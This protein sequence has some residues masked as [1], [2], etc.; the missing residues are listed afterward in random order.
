MNRYHDGMKIGQVDGAMI[1]LVHGWRFRLFGGYNLSLFLQSIEDRLELTIKHS[2]YSAKY[3]ALDTLLVLELTGTAIDCSS[4][5][6]YSI[7]NIDDV[8]SEDESSDT[9]YL[10]NIHIYKMFKAYWKEKFEEAGEHFQNSLGTPG[11]KTPR[12]IT[13]HQTLYGGLV[14]FQLHRQMGGNNDLR[15]QQGRAAMKKLEEWPNTHHG[16]KMLLLQAEHSGTIGE[17]DK[18]QLL[19]R[20][21][22]KAAKDHGNVHEL[23]LSYELFGNHYCLTNGCGGEDSNECFRNACV[24]YE[25]W[26]AIAL[27]EKIRRKHN[28][29][30]DTGASAELQPGKSK[31]SRNGD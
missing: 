6:G 12:F 22:I 5:F 8:R 4:A 25:Q 19:Y 28:L 17:H 20:A 10:T 13:I 27:A 11:T 21:S 31:H 24:Y 14:A 3:M 16:N 29:R 1:A 15:L 2:K 30:M 18:A 23:A 7:S 9:V 26:G